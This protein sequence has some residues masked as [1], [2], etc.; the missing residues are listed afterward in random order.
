[1]T[2]HETPVMLFSFQQYTATWAGHARATTDLVQWVHVPAK[3]L[4]TLVDTLA[5]FPKLEVLVVDVFND[6]LKDLNPLDLSTSLAETLGGYYHQIERSFDVLPK[7]KV[8]LTM[9][10][11]ILCNSS[12]TA[13]FFWT[14]TGVS[15]VQAHAIYLLLH[16]GPVMA[17]SFITVHIFYASI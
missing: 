10:L 17:G 9:W 8:S 14:R 5:Q 16:C 15:I 13:A 3:N 1:M 2:A 12:F 11:T 7:L 4:V 6:L